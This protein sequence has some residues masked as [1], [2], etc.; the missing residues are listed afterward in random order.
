MVK[1][2]FLTS[3][4]AAGTTA[5]VTPTQIRT[6][7]EGR[8][9]VALGISGATVN[10]GNL[11]LRVNGVELTNNGI[12][13]GVTRTAGQVIDQ[14]SDVIEINYDVNENEVIEMLVTNTSAG[15]LTYYVFY[16]ILDASD[17]E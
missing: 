11:R 16:D 9:I 8:R 2:V 4:I 7:P 10:T 3:S 14:A 12:P 15:A 17:M 6:T 1:Q 5:D 13:N